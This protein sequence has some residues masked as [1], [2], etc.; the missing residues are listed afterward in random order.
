M[1]MIRIFSVLALVSLM[2]SGCVTSQYVNKENCECTR[3]YF[4]PL[5][6]TTQSCSDEVRPD[7]VTGQ[8]Q[9]ETLDVAPDAPSPSLRQ[10]S[11]AQAIAQNIKATARVR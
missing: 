8:A 5:G 6:I 11:A 4:T 10:S 7:A 1:T 2:G 3:N 9:G